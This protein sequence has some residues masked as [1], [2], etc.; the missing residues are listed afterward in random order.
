MARPLPVLGAALTLDMLARH[1]DW[2]LSAPRDL[3]IQSFASARALS[4]DMRPLIDRARG[5]LDGHSG[6]LGLHGPFLGFAIDAYDPDVAEVVR[7][8]MLACLDACAAL[9]ADQMV[10]HSPVTIWDHSN[11][12][13]EP[14]EEPI[15]IER[16]R[17]LMAPVIAR[18]E[19]E[20]VTLVIENVED[21]DP[22][23]RCRL[24]DAL[25]S[26][27]VAV[28]LDTGHAHYAHRLAGAPPVDV[29]IHAAGKRLQHVH[30]QDTDG[31]ADRHWHPGEGD[32][33]W[34]SVFAALGSL[35]QMPRLILEVNDQRGLLRGAEHLAAMGLAI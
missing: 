22:A 34:R 35:R 14:A 16:V 23:A 7:R 2:V 9:G 25:N 3:E 6:R 19:A 30:L 10:I 17:W 15:Q 13:A 21:I 11:H 18:A 5:L 24:A 31:Y 29:F 33:N 8:R 20:G 27:A 26:P 32:L 4:G 12:L 28:S 1:R